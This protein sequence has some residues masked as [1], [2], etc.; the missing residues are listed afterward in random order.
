MQ[1]KLEKELGSDSEET[2]KGRAKRP[3]K[4]SLYLLT[5]HSTQEPSSK[6]VKM[7][8]RPRGIQMLKNAHTGREKQSKSKGYGGT[9]VMC[10]QKS[11]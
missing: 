2:C 11:E 10:S 4:P 6:G 3:N 5:A 7:Q 9:E 8:D 1:T